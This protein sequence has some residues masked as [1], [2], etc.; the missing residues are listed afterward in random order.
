MKISEIIRAWYKKNMRS[1]PWRSTTDPYLIWLSEIILQQTRVKQGLSYYLKFSER[2][3][4]VAMLAEA[5]EDEVLNLW[6]GLGYYSRARNLQFAARQIVHDLDG[7]FPDSY[8]ALLQLK[9]VG[10]YTASAIASI[11]YHEPV[12]VVDGNVAR[13]MI[14]HQLTHRTIFARFV[15]VDIGSIDFE[16]PGDCVK[17]LE[18]NIGDYPVPRLIDRY[19]M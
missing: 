3:P 11:A 8:Q 14:R 9:G 19:L 10:T 16:A 2:F 18:T 1:L 17:I 15:H 5:S 13:E 7:K 4:Q 12:A 6:Q